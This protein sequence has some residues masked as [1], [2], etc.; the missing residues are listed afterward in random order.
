MWLVFALLSPLFWAIVT[1]LDRHC[2]ERIFDRPWMGVITSA[3][4]SSSS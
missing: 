4:A 3:L 1:V 2:V